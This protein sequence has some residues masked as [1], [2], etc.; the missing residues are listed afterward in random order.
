MPNHFRKM[1]KSYEEIKNYPN[2]IKYVK[3]HPEIGEKIHY[4]CSKSDNDSSIDNEEKPQPQQVQP[5][6]QK[7]KPESQKPKITQKIK[8]SLQN[9]LIIL[10]ANLPNQKMTVNQKNLYLV[11]MKKVSLEVY[12]V[13]LI[14]L[15]NNNL[16]YLVILENQFLVIFL[17]EDLYLE[18]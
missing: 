5:E 3:Y 11:K 7:E 4:Q 6:P 17:L 14:I 10:T 16:V 2:C 1:S 9:L 8:K 18:I 13:I 12:S 15:K